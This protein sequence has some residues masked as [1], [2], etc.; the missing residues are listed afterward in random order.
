MIT[1]TEHETIL[2]AID[3]DLNFGEKV[4]LRKVNFDIKNIVRAGLS[5]GQVISWIG[6]SGVGKS[7][8]FK[9]CAGLIK[10]TA[11]QVKIG[12]EQKDVKAGN[13][14]IVPQNY[15]LFNHRSIRSNLHIAVNHCGE[16]L[17]EKEKQNRI[18]VLAEEFG[19]TEHLNKYP[20]Q[21]SGG[22]RQRVSIL[23]QILT[24]NKF[25]LMDEPFSGLDPIMIDK[26]VNLIR[27]ISLMDELNTIVIV[28]HDIS[29]AMAISDTTFVLAPEEGKSGA[30]I[31]KV[32][33]LKAMGLAWRPDIK[34]DQHFRDVV[35]D[36]KKII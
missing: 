35:E 16:K 15:I 31:T 27:K 8:L 10:P 29:N 18:E 12:V 22:Q 24:G 11:G 20:M 30:T 26:V 7:Q 2:K 4:V 13:V 1:Y 17:Q 25:I 28:S 21:L 6:R 5:Q 19:L 9:I 3:I 14:G 32:I 23:Q 34:R 36:I 33:D